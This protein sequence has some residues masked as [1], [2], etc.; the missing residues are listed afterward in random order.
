MQNCGRPM[1]LQNKCLRT[2]QVV[3][4]CAGSSAQL[5]KQFAALPTVQYHHQCTT[6][7]LPTPPQKKQVQESPQRN[8]RESEMRAKVE[9]MTQWAHDTPHGAAHMQQ[10]V[11][12]KPP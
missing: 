12:P 11:G 2:P 1:R 7:H 5:C 9:F 6:Q 4:Q 10:A 8:Y 3:L